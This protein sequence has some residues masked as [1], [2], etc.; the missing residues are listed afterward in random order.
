MQAS[1][2]DELAIQARSRYPAGHF[3]L[4][5]VVEVG[6]GGVEDEVSIATLP[7]LSS[8]FPVTHPLVKINF[9]SQPLVLDLTIIVLSILFYIERICLQKLIQLHAE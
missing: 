7:P 4:R 6:G 8:L 1:Y 9:S 2:Q 5:V 3:W